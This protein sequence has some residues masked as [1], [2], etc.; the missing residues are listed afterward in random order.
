MCRAAP[1]KK[2]A[3]MQKKQANNDPY[4]WYYR[5]IGAVLIGFIANDLC[6]VFTKKSIWFH[7]QNW[8]Q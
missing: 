3:L 4:K 2:N 7:L 1:I 5:A 6:E 8:I